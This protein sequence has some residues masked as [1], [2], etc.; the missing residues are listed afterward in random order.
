MR[1][2]HAQNGTETKLNASGKCNEP[3]VSPPSEKKIR[4][5]INNTVNAAEQWADANCLLKMLGRLNM[6]QAISRRCICAAAGN[7]CTVKQGGEMDH[8]KGG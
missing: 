4:E 3:T 2:W 1:A 8:A 5:K 7:F 6:L